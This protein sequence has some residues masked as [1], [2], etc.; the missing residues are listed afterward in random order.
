MNTKI[1]ARTL[2]WTT[3]GVASALAMA[4]SLGTA[5][6]AAAM[7]MAQG[8]DS[9]PNVVFPA[10][11]IP[12]TQVMA[13]DLYD[14]GFTHVANVTTNG[15]YYHATAQWDG[16]PVNLRIDGYTGTISLG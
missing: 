10:P 2:R 6:P 3:L 16:K 11:S 1:S 7:N 9:M 12:N 13:A 14:Q 5:Q 4:F 15:N 8:D